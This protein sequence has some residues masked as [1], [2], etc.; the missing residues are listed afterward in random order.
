MPLEVAGSCNHAAIAKAV[1]TQPF[2]K[3]KTMKGDVCAVQRLQ[4]SDRK[5]DRAGLKL[6]RKL[7]KTKR[8]KRLYSKCKT[9]F[10]FELTRCADDTMLLA[11]EVVQTQRNKILKLKD[12]NGSRCFYIGEIF[13]FDGSSA[14]VVS[15]RRR[16]ELKGFE[17]RDDK[18][19]HLFRLE[20]DESILCQKRYDEDNNFVFYVSTMPRETAVSCPFAL[21]LDNFNRLQSTVSLMLGLVVLPHQYSI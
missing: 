7:D 17:Q 12:S 1:S 9:A 2:K 21:S 19:L 10:A 15:P 18:K 4:K 5:A 11:N 20:N 6:K 14:L 3:T 8:N 16:C 13:S